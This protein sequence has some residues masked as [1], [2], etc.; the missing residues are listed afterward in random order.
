M[1]ADTTCHN[2]VHNLYISPDVISL[3]LQLVVKADLNCVP[4]RGCVVFHYRA[5]FPVVLPGVGETH[6]KHEGCDGQDQVG[7]LDAENVFPQGI[8][9]HFVAASFEIEIDQLSLSTVQLGPEKRSGG[10]QKQKTNERQC[11][12]M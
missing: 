6:Y 12:Y 2:I 9:G 7:G 3:D 11:L 8:E 1:T 10:W 5:N 4:S